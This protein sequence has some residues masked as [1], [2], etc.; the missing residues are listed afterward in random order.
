MSKLYPAK[1]R[2]WTELLDLIKAG[3]EW[4]NSNRSFRGVRKPVDAAK[5]P[6]REW[7]S[8]ADYHTM[9]RAQ[10]MHGIDYLVFSWDTVIAYRNGKGE[11]WT[12]NQN[13]SKSTTFHQNRIGVVANVLNEELVRA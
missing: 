7:M 8:V 2:R 3:H 6:A 4:H 5:L 12:S 9:Q 13:H 1:Q 10:D 11:W